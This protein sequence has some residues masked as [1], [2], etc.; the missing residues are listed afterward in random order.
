[1]ESIRYADR[2]ADTSAG[3]LADLELRHLAALRAVAEEGSFGRAAARL[4]FTQSAVSQ[5]IAGLERIVGEPVFDRPGGPRPVTLTPLGALLLP[6]AVTVLDRLGCAEAELAGFRAGELA[7]ITVGTFQSVSVRIVPGVLKELR[8]RHPGIDVQLVEVDEDQELIARLRAGELDASFLVLP[9]DDEDELDLVPV[10]EDALVI[11]CPLDSPILPPDGGA[12]PVERLHRLPLVGQPSTT[13][14]RLIEGRLRS[15]GV[16]PETFFRT[17]G[18]DAV[19]AMV[20][21]GMGH[22]VMGA[23]AVDRDDPGVQVREL[24]PPLPRRSIVLASVKSRRVPPALEPFVEVTLEVARS[25]V[26]AHAV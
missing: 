15:A 13:C 8:E 4:G 22:A 25:L 19:Q 6:H 1:M 24:D 3:T 7:T 12:V 10:I 9:L 26:A 18:N 23:L 11:V 16:E 21:S 14:S 5:Q 17:A 20:R 2:V